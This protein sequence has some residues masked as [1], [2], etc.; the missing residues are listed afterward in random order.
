M[1]S[2]K[3]LGKFYQK[4][5][6]KFYQ[7]AAA[8]YLRSLRSLDGTRKWGRRD[9]NSGLQQFVIF[10]LDIFQARK[11]SPQAGRMVQSTLRPRKGDG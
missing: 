3:T 2:D 10:F 9:L 11:K 4:T 6:G 1:G 8:S 7:R 5:L